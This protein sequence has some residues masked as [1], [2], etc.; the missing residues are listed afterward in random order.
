VVEGRVLDGYGAPIANALVLLRRGDRPVAWPEKGAIRSNSLG[1]YQIELSRIEAPSSKIRTQVI[2]HGFASSIQNIDTATAKVTVDFALKPGPWKTTEIRMIDPAG[3]PAAGIELKCV[4]GDVTWS[5]LKT[6]ADGRCRVAMAIDQRMEANCAPAGVRPI[7]FGL[8]NTKDGPAVLTLALQPPIRGRVRDR[9]GRP[10]PNVTLGRS[11]SLDNSKPEMYPHLFSGLATTDS[12]GR[13]EYSPTVLL[14][15]RDFERPNRQGYP[16]PIVFADHDFKRLA[17]GLVNIAGPIEP[18]DITLEPARLVRIPIE[19]ASAPSAAGAVGFLRAALVPRHDIPEFKVLVLTTEVSNQVVSGSKSLEVALPAGKFVFT[20]EYF[21]DGAR[22]PTRTVQEEVVPPGEGTFDLPA[23]RAE[24]TVHE[25]MIGTLA[26]DIEAVDRDTGQPVSLADFRRKV[27]VLDFW[28][29]WCG[30]CIGDMPY[31]VDLHSRFKGRPLAIVALHDQSVQSRAEYDRRTAFAQK[32]AWNGQG[33]PFRV[34]LDRP[35]PL[36][37][38]A[39]APE[40]TGL[41]CKLYQIYAFPTLLVI[42]QEGKLVAKINRGQSEHE[43]LESL[44]NKLL[45]QPPSPKSGP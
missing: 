3:H 30:P 32:N 37:P 26:P 8:M 34:L 5:Q 23:L 24:P 28:G 6:D 27:V 13:F 17:I 22:L 15:E 9:Q 45:D 42:D 1:R 20:V 16:F 40:G 14:S 41:T 44:I 18:L 29:Y 4:L 10:V 25:R 31:L 19:Q 11:I 43:R 36:K 38:P 21:A 2:A 33:L 12:E 35:D 7:R 39:R